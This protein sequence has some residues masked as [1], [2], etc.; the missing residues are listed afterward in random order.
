MCS[1]NRVQGAAAVMLLF[2]SRDRACEQ[3][4]EQQ[5]ADAERQR[6]AVLTLAD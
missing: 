1:D 4:V 6:L 2:T 3:L 5:I